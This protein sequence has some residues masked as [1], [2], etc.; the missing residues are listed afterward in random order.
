MSD[1]LAVRGHFLLLRQIFTNSPF[2]LFACS[3]PNNPSRILYANE[4]AAS[5]STYAPSIYATQTYSSPTYAP[6]T[7]APSYAAEEANNTTAN[8]SKTRYVRTLLQIALSVFE[9][10]ISSLYLSWSYLSV[11]MSLFSCC[12]GR[13]CDLSW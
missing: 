4:T 1:C 8:A 6:Q 5:S 12:I 13:L 10:W 3:G 11:F 2:F 7:Y 9:R